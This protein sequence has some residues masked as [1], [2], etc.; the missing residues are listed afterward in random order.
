MNKKYD[1]KTADGRTCCK[2]EHLCQHCREAADEMAADI[3]PVPQ[4]YGA[5]KDAA[6]RVEIEYNENGTPDTYGLGALRRK[7]GTR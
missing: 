7:R 2:G 5:L 3:I 1:F 4:P 6:Q